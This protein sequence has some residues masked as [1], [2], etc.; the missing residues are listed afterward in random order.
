[1]LGVGRSRWGIADDTEGARFHNQGD[2][3]DDLGQKD[4]IE[5]ERDII[6]ASQSIETAGVAGDSPIRA[7][8]QSNSQADLIRGH[9]CIDLI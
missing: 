4:K 1:M 9:I 7:P 3:V 2:L 8:P 5:K 6:V